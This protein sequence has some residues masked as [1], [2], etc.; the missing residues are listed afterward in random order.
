MLL[1]DYGSACELVRLATK[2][3]LSTVL[4]QRGLAPKKIVVSYITIDD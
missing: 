2:M 4:A 3:A 1:S